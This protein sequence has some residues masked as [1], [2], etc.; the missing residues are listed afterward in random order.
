MPRKVTLF[1]STFLGLL[2]FLAVLTSSELN[3]QVYT[4][5]WGFRSEWIVSVSKQNIDHG[6]GFG[7]NTS[8][9]CSQ[10]SQ[11]VTAVALILGDHDSVVLAWPSAQQ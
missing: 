7:A 8:L 9:Q 11:S 1:S 2:A 6:A 5:N 10:R 4:L 3:K